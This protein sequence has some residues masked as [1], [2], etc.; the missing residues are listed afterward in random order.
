MDYRILLKKYIEHVCDHEGTSY[1]TDIH[2]AR[3]GVFTDA[4]WAELER[5]RDEVLSQQDHP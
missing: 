2:K 5:L 3:L 4:E 1:I